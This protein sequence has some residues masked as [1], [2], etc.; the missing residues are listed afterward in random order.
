MEWC[1]ISEYTAMWTCLSLVVLCW[2]RLFWPSTTK[3]RFVQLFRVETIKLSAAQMSRLTRCSIPFTCVQ[4]QTDSKQF[5]MHSSCCSVHWCLLSAFD[6][7]RWILRSLSFSAEKFNPIEN[8][9]K[10]FAIVCL[11]W[12]SFGSSMALAKY[13][14]FHLIFSSP[15]SARNGLRIFSITIFSRLNDAT[16]SKLS[17]RMEWHI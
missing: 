13:N 10:V 15:S 4:F 3:C 8:P 7:Y 14:A 17:N 5:L 11:P 6:W 9:T 2:R 12:R 1:M 16:E